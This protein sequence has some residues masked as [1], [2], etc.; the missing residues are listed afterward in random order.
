MTNDTRSDISPEIEAPKSAE[1][2]AR[3]VDALMRLAAERKFEDIAIRDICAAADVTLADFRDAFPSK[4][5]VLGGFT[6]RIDRA[7]LSHTGNELAAEAP[8][9]RLFD[10]LMRRL[11]AMTP[12]RDGLREIMAWLRRD[13]AAALAM[14][15]VSVNSMRFMLE[16]AAIDSDGAAGVLKLQGLTFA[17][18]RVLTVWLDDSEPALSRTMAALDRELTQGERW[19]AGVDRLERLAAPF[20]AIARAAMETSSRAREGF[21]KRPPETA[22]TEDASSI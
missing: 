12:Y 17:W 22:A 19:V 5:A 8:R 21:R 14:N 3:I 16:A 20:K 10:V 13:P 4:G 2:R 7:V 11:D 6:K 15:R 18:A 9:E 1:P